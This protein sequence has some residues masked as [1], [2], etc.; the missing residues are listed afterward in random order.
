MI[1]ERV[2]VYYDKNRSIM[3]EHVIDSELH[4]ALVIK[5]HAPE[6]Y[7]FAVIEER[8]YTEKNTN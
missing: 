6:K 3:Y 8:Y 5:L 1:M 7:D 2:V 4:D